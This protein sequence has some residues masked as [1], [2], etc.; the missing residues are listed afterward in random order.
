MDDEGEGGGGDVR[1]PNGDVR[2]LTGA[3]RPRRLLVDGDLQ[4][5]WKLRRFA[6]GDA[7]SRDRRD[8]DLCGSLIGRVV[9]FVGRWRDVEYLVVGGLEVNEG[10]VRESGFVRGDEF[11]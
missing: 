1:C 5:G 11:L 3:P 7:E 6:L 8:E 10:E 2:D 9:S 4:S